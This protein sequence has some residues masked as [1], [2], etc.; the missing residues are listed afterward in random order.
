K[1]PFISPSIAKS[2]PFHLDTCFRA[3]WQLLKGLNPWLESR[4]LGSKMRLRT[5]SMAF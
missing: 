4:N 3:E 2:Y 1:Y 5:T